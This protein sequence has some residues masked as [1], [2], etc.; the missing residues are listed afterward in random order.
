MEDHRDLGKESYKLW[1]EH[2]QKALHNWTGSE[3]SLEDKKEA[4]PRV[5]QS[6]LRWPFIASRDALW[7]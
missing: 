3:L 4:T 6:C 7:V 2:M 1:T 5:L